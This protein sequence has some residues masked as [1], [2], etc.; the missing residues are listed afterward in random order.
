MLVLLSSLLRELY[1][2]TL[3]IFKGRT[4][5]QKEVNEQLYKEANIIAL[6]ANRKFCGIIIDEMKVKENLVYDMFT[7]EVVGF[8]SLDDINDE[9]LS[10]ERQCTTEQY[11]P[12]IAKYLLVLMVRGLFFKLDVPYAH[13]ATDGI[14]GEFLFPRVWE[15]ICRIERIGL[16][17]VFI[18]ADGASPNRTFFRM[19]GTGE[20][21]TKHILS[22][23]YMTLCF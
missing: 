15:A 21:D 2:I 16:Q 20:L 23:L 1:G 3:T 14:T 5:F 7:G 10:L 12:P 13:F 17:V 18:T 22:L 19:H 6:S 9:L 11:H 8:V 4:G